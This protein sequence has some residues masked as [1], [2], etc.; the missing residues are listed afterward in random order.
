MDLK[1]VVKKHNLIRTHR[2]IVTSLDKKSGGLGS[3]LWLYNQTL[4]EIVFDNI[5]IKLVGSLC[6]YEET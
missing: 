1:V 4:I 3:S 6:T 2:S 5:V